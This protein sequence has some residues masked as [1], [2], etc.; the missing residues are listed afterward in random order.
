[1]WHVMG[2]WFEPDVETTCYSTDDLYEALEW[3]K[4]HGYE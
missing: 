2:Y 4:E 3:A 1:M